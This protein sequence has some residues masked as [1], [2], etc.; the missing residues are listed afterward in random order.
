MCEC[1]FVRRW[2]L[3]VVLLLWLLKAGSVGFAPCVVA[4]RGQLLTATEAPGVNLSLSSLVKI[5]TVMLTRG[6]AVV[7]V[8]VVV[9]FV[10]S[11]FL[12]WGLFG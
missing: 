8:V 5:V 7:V 3:R 1:V 2:K 10:V 12:L 9:A 6:W 11:L 4:S